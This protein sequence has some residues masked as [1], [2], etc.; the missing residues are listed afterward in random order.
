MLRS[1]QGS[2][3]RIR[4]ASRESSGLRHYDHHVSEWPAGRARHGGVDEIPLPEGPGRL[5]LCGKH[6][7]GPDPVAA[8]S[9]SGAD[10]IVCLCEPHELEERYPGYVTWLSAADRRAAIW[11]PIPDLHAPPLAAVEPLLDCLQRLVDAGRGILMHCGAGIGRAGTLAA[12]L[13]MQM[14]V[15]RPEALSI[16]AAGRPLAG[17]EA[18]AQQELLELLARTT[19]Q[20]AVDAR[21]Q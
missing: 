15:G 21:R 13:L 7:V 20:P 16:V 5:W 11:F 18:G 17:P 10:V 14:G 6:F 12:A 19:S 9:E 3:K 2:G 4:R 8:L 1:L